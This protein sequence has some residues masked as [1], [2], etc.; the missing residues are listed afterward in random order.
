[1]IGGAPG[2]AVALPT[3]PPESTI[4]GN[5]SAGMPSAASTRVSHVD[6]SRV[7]WR[8]VT[9]ALVASV[10]WTAPRESVHATHVSTVPKHSSVARRRS[11][12]WSRIHCSFVADW[13]GLER[14]P[15]DRRLRH[16]P[17]VR[18]S[19]QP[20][21]GPTGSPVARSQTTV[22]PRWLEIPTASTGPLRPSASVASSTHVAAIARASNC[23]IPSAGESGSNSRSRPTSAVP[24]ASNTPTRTL[25][26]PTSTTS[27]RPFVM[28][29]RARRTGCADRASPG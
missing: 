13:F 14:T 18:R 9:A 19:C 23:T 5:I 4:A 26:V 27:T 24:A 7:T 28:A 11:G 1:M 16:A 15:W 3:A 22:E 12:S 17:I 29:R 21:P 10:T 6:G 2:S 8:P 20:I 25:L